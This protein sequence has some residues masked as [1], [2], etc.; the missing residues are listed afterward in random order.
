MSNIPDPTIPV[1]DPATRRTAQ[2]PPVSGPPDPTDLRN[3]ALAAHALAEAVTDALEALP[4]GTV[5]ERILM[6]GVLCEEKCAAVFTGTDALAAK[7]R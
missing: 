7:P 5:D 4:P 2:R 3:D 6:L 1:N